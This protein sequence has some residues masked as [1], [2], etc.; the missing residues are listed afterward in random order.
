MEL[1]D[2]PKV[3]AFFDERSG[4]TRFVSQASYER[5]R[6][7]QS[8][9]TGGVAGASQ[10]FGGRMRGKTVNSVDLD[11][12]MDKVSLCIFNGLLCTFHQLIVG[13][14]STH[15]FLPYSLKF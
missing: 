4:H 6:N 13:C 5:L 2:D 12:Q 8:L 7:R 9:E 11:K 1:D 14:C 10:F 15:F 3:V